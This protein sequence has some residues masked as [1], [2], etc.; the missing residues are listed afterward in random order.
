[1]AS[2]AVQGDQAAGQQVLTLLWPE[3]SDTL[4][5]T[6]TIKCITQAML[7]LTMNTSIED[8][9]M[10]MRLTM[11]RMSAMENIAIMASRMANIDY[12]DFRGYTMDTLGTLS[13]TGTI[14]TTNTMT[15]GTLDITGTMGLT[16]TMCIMGI[17]R[18]AAPINTKS[19]SAPMAR[20]S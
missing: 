15:V 16:Y 11:S 5:T 6:N 13:T 12:I 19:I 17:P 18:I 9:R 3:M 20:R 7:E 8:M 14:S 2:L 1:L 10:C 4:D